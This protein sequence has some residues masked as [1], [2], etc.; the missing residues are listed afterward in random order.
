MM[1]GNIQRLEVVVGRL[2]LRPLHH[3]EA[4]GEEN[5]LQLFG[6]LANQVARPNRSL[7]AGKRKIDALARLRR[8]F[9]G[10]FNCQLG[11]PRAPF[12]RAT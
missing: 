10:G 11:A 9:G 3:A 12:P 6:G 7:D 1:F 4:D 2:D 5:A 8:V